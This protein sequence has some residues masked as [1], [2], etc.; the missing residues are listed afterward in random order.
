MNDHQQ[1]GRP[2]AGGSAHPGRSTQTLARPAVP[3][4]GGDMR[5]RGTRRPAPVTTVDCVRAASECAPGIERVSVDRVLKGFIEKQTNSVYE[6]H[7]WKAFA[8]QFVPGQRPIRGEMVG[9]F[10]GS[11]MQAIRALTVLA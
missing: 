1:V 3:M 2:R 4:K 5:R 9:V 11:R 8:P 6:T 7:P 10:Y